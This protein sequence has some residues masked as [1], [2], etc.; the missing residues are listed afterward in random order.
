[1]LDSTRQYVDTVYLRDSCCKTALLWGSFYE[2]RV[3][4]NKIKLDGAINKLTSYD[5]FLL[6]GL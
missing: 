1:M 2:D 6:L 3:K 4:K 5:S